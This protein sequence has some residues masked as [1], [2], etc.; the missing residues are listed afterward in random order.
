MKRL[1]SDMADHNLLFQLFNQIN[2]VL[3]ISCVIENECESKHVILEE[4][5]TKTI[6]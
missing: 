6:Q 4:S 3:R 5:M 2:D 1:Y